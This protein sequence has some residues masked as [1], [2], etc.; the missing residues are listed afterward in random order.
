MQFKLIQSLRGIAA[1]WVVL[2]HA[3]EG[4]H[5]DHLK[6][7]LPKHLFLFVFEHG[8]MGVAIFFALSGFVIAHSVR[9]AS[10]TWA[11]FGRFA[12]R[13]SIRLD[14]PY[15][16]AIALTVGFA[17]LSAAVKSEPSDLP[18]TSQ[19]LAHLTYTQVFLGYD[20]INSV[21]WTLT[22]EV[23]F[24]L[25]LVA[26]I[27]LAQRYGN[28]VVAPVLFAIAIAW[29]T[30]ILPEV[31]GLFVNLW[32]S[33]FIGALAYWGIADSKKAAALFALGGI[34][35]VFPSSTFTAVAV[36]AAFGL[37]L[38]GRT[39]YLA[40]GLGSRPFQFLG[41]ISYSLY[42]T[43]LPVGGAAFFLLKASRVSE[44][45][46]LPISV[47]VCIVSAAAFWWILEKPSLALAKRVRL[48]S[49]HRASANTPGESASG[50][51]IPGRLPPN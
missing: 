22:Y 36:L 23:Q 42:L 41:A 8:N 3:S 10:V 29:G 13:R 16:A 17:V 25:V 34:L 38:A 48:K 4:G 7:V 40:D 2:F 44:W 35:I 15:W 19:V 33:F 5:I 31:Q 24:Y 9:D 50:T 21:F 18:T 47:L 45:L 51:S 6:G 43:H 32:H 26:A 1:L 20:E 28:A 30:G 14:P 49:K 12:L 39:G 11:Y 46:A 37:Y 27:G